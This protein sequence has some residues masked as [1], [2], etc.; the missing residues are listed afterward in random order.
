MTNSR[1]R[2]IAFSANALCQFSRRWRSIRRTLARAIIIAVC[3]WRPCSS[4]EAVRLEVAAGGSEELNRMI[5]D[6][7]SI[8]DNSPEGYSEVYRIAG[9]LDLSAM[10]EL[11]KI[12][13]REQLRD[14]PFSPQMPR[15]LRRRDDLFAT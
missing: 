12:A 13:D 4:G 15:G 6:E 1:P 10:M 5:I 7:E 3:T 9:P 8:R 2:S 14:P 11:V